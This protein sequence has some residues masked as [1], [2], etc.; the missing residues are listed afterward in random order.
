LPD[1]QAE[2]TLLIFWSSECPHCTEMMPKLKSL[3]DNQN[4]RKLQVMAVSL[5]TIRNAWTSYIRKEKLNWI[6][7]SDLRGFEGKAEDEYNVFAT[8]TMYLLDRD[9]KII[10]KPITWRELEQSLRENKIINQ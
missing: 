3:Y 2:F 5:D 6:N 10:S 9:K 7:V 1:I 8:P 4:P